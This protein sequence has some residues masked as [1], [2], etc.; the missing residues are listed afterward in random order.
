MQIRTKISETKNVLEK[1][2]RCDYV[3][4]YMTIQFTNHITAEV[5]VM[6]NYR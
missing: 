4:K 3:K 6:L 1:V 5:S 2:K